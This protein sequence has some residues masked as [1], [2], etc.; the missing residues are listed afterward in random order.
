MLKIS[1]LHA[2]I[3]GKEI[4]RGL[5]LEVLP[6]EVHAIMGPNGSGKST[7]AHTLA[8]K[9]AYKVTRGSAVLD[10]EEPFSLGSEERAGMGLFLPFSYP[11]EVPGG[12][13]L[14]F[15]KCF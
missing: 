14:A 11:V 9:D 10:T 3:E 6:G 12:N 8:G 13:K 7:L 5:D 15:L 1:D 2:E 4:L